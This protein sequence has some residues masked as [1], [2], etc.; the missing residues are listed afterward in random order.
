MNTS[1]NTSTLMTSGVTGARETALGWFLLIVASVVV[2]AIT[3]LVLMAALR[4]REVNPVGDS[5]ARAEQPGELR[6]ITVGGLMIPAVVL[7]VAFL[8]TVFTIDAVGSPATPVVAHVTVTGHQWWWEAR[9]DDSVTSNTFSTANEI[10]VP[11]GEPVQ[12]DLTTAD[13]IHS[14]WV[15]A[16]AGKVDLIPGQH[17]TLWLE[18]KEPGTYTGPCGEY[19]GTQHANMRVTVVAESPPRFHAWLTTQRAAAAAPMDSLHAAGRDAFAHAGCAMC[20][21]IRGTATG[22]GVGPDLTHLASRRELAAGSLVN[23]PGT[24]MTWIAGA[25]AIKPGC[26]M[27]NMALNA[28]DLVAL[29]AY[30]ETLK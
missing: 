29:V 26:D 3:V 7:G 8:F 24:L 2:V 13:V 5:V 12:F 15:P 25:Q 10:H 19:C 4:K 9:Y 1:V 21:T 23:S 17:N 6:W 14:F 27:P 16:L 20:H 11:V 28:P 30:L 18:A 22:G